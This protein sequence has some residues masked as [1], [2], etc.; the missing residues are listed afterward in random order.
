MFKA[1]IAL[2]AASTAAHPEYV[3]LLPV[4]FFAVTG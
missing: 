3:A 2:F 1:A 4:R